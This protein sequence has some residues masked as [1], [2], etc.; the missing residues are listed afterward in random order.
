MIHAHYQNLEDQYEQ[1]GKYTGTYGPY[2]ARMFMEFDL[3]QDKETRSSCVSCQ[4]II[5][6]VFQDAERL[7][8]TSAHV[9]NFYELLYMRIES[10]LQQ[11]RRTLRLYRVET[12]ALAYPTARACDPQ[13]L[14]IGLLRKWIDR[15]QASHGSKCLS[16]TISPP[17]HQIYLIDNEAGCLVHK[18]ADCRYVALSYVCGQIPRPH[19]T[20]SNLPALQIPGS[21]TAEAEQLTIPKTIRDALRL[22]SLLGER[23]LWVDSFCIVQDEE[24][25]K[26]LQ[27]S[28]MASIYANAY[29]TIA[30]AEGK[31]ADHGISGITRSAGAREIDQGRFHLSSGQQMIAHNLGSSFPGQLRDTTWNT[32]GWTF[33]EGLFSPRILLFNGTV[34]WYCRSSIWE[35][36]IRD[37]REDR[38]GTIGPRKPNDY[39]ELAYRQPQWPDLDSWD[40]LVGEYNSR[41]LTFDRDIINAFAG[42]AAIF[43]GH[44]DGGL[45]WGI[46]EMFFDHC[47]TWKPFG[48]LRRRK[49]DS[50]SSRVSR[51][52]SWSWV[53]WEG[54]VI[55][56]GFRPSIYRSFD[57]N[58]GYDEL[59]PMVEW[60]KS[61]TSNAV[62]SVRFPVRNTF[63]SIVSAHQHK[64]QEACPEG[65]TKITTPKGNQKYTNELVPSTKFRLPI[66]LSN[67][68]IASMPDNESQVL[69]FK[70]QHAWFLMGQDV[71]T[72]VWPTP[73]VKLC[74]PFGK[75]AGSLMLHTPYSD[76]LPIG[77]SCEL[78]ALSLATIDP[79]SPACP[80]LDT[81]L[82][83]LYKDSEAHKFYY[84]MWIEWESRIAYRK[85]VGKVDKDMWDQQTPR[86]IDVVLG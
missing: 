56:Q 34:S 17:S 7:T 48:A 26:E 14:D 86:T 78:L 62:A 64:D 76:P 58:Y 66:P 69:H 79:D 45:L 41:K 43:Q 19:T 82:P 75:R 73:C 81:D 4:N 70:A 24:N 5:N 57:V 2:E 6:S 12:P 40:S 29:F 33:Q 31:D 18:S 65:W 49:R 35:E 80:G 11:T 46:P 21:I 77:E 72:P 39:L 25:T 60:Y 85:A 42:A 53:G 20:K 61:K 13:Q 37:P 1:S 47:I 3:L 36:A 67:H 10:P 68:D 83:P 9:R 38:A 15:C 8:P 30:A 23:Y 74:D 59:Q 52:P 51:L 71:R 28:S 55:L 54:Y 44:F 27:L 16:H 22:V 50:D 84:V 32:R 63:H